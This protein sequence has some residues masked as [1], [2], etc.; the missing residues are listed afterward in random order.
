MR[1][2]AVTSLVLLA[3]TVAATGARGTRSGTAMPADPD[4]LVGTGLHR[5]A[6]SPTVARRASSWCGTTSTTDRP[7]AVTGYPIRI[8]YAIPSD[9]GDQSATAAPQISD[10]LDQLTSWW[11]REDP[12]RTPRWDVYAA[13][14]GTQVDLQVLRLPTVS[15]ATT[16]PH[17]VFAQVWDT[18]Q[19]Q[20]DAETTKYLVFVDDID[21][22]NIC[23]VGGPASGSTVGQLSM[24]VATVFLASCDGADRATV[25]GHELLHAVSPAGGF[26]GSPHTCPGDLYH[27]CDSTGDILYPYVGEGIPVTSLQLDVGHDDYWA[28]SAPVNLQVQPWFRHV[29]DQVHLGLTI[30]GEGSVQSSVPGVTCNAACGSDWDRGT[31]VSLSTTAG[32][33]YKFVRWSGGCTGA[34]DCAL[35]LGASTDVTALFAPSTFPLTVHVAGSG[36]VTSSPRGLACKHAACAHPFSS[37]QP[38]LLTAKPAKGWRFAGW[39]GACRGKRTSCTL[40]MT[41]PSAARAAFAK[42]R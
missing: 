42:K 12:S 16:D 13:P 32:T 29:Q 26:V 3:L 34:G 31:A 19:A 37:Y 5:A 1:F 28:G 40:Q 10:I 27:V 30:T 41:A 2:A 14:C 36:T 17:E 8:Y 39:A 6:A 15:V 21:T 18:L 9:G 20:P 4:V 33:G 22:G 25:A 24:G 23:G 11:Q 7:P 35:T 38:V